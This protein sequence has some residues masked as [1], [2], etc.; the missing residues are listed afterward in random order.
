MQ[1]LQLKLYTYFCLFTPRKNT[2]KPIKFQTFIDRNMPIPDILRKGQDSM[3]KAVEHLTNELTKFRTGRATPQLLD[4]VRVDYYGSPTQL[5]QVA[6]ISAIDAR[7]LI[8]QPWEKTMLQPIERAIREADLGLNP[9][10]DGSVVRVPIP[11]L[12]EERRKDIVKMVKK[13]AEESRVTIRNVRRDTIETLKKAEKTEHFSEDDR[14]R[15]EEDAQ[16]HTDK[17][18]KIVDELLAK[19]EKEVLEV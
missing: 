5:S 18:I 12:S 9:S 1:K 7:T 10:N 15:A 4:H 6:N 14:K 3:N 11:P 17:Y 19:K 8:V 13:V 2:I 16:K